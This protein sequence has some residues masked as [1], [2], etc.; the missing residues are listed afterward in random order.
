MFGKLK[1]KR[2]GNYDFDTF[3]DLKSF[4]NDPD[5]QLKFK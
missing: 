3:E 4:V 5:I 1:S 2:I